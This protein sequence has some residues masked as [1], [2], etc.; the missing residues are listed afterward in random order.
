M[1]IWLLGLGGTHGPHFYLSFMII[2]LTRSGISPG[3]FFAANEIKALFAHIIT[4]YDI[5]FEEGKGVPRQ[6]C[7]AGFRILG[8]ANVMFRARQK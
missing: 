1:N 8:K 7:I 3:R 6:R 4:S 2:D 5:K